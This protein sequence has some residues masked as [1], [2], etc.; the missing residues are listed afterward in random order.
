MCTWKGGRRE[1]ERV[2]RDEEKGE[3]D[4]VALCRNEANQT[5]QLWGSSEF[6]VAKSLNVEVTLLHISYEV[7]VHEQNFSARR[8]IP[9]E[10]LG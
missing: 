5:S 2:V 10:T 7:Q 6:R 4:V 9:T 3:R 1:R 8:S